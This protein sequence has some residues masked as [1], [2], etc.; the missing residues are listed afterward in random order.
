[1]N[2]NENP[3][4]ALRDAA[5]QCNINNDWNRLYY[6]KLQCLGKLCI[7]LFSILNVYWW[8]FSLN[9]MWNKSISF[10]N[11]ISFIDR[12]I[13]QMFYPHGIFPVKYNKQNINDKFLT[14]V[15]AFV[16]FIYLCFLF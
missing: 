3:L 6:T 8:L 2:I 16:V 15:L 13:K 10:S 5:F 14:S 9:Y 11:L 1:M 4:Y 12:Q 7:I